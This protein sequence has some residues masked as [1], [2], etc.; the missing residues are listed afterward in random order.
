M[1]MLLV[2]LGYD[3]FF[4]LGDILLRIAPHLLECLLKMTFLRCERAIDLCVKVARFVSTLLNFLDR[5]AK[6]L[7]QGLVPLNVYGGKRR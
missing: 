4:S 6:G 2:C 7:I 5:H 1:I 3:L